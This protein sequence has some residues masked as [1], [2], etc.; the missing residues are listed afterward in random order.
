V[1]EVTG[2]LLNVHDLPWS[3]GEFPA[4]SGTIVIDDATKTIL[5]VYPNP[6]G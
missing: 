6:G 4:P 2:D 3:K 1:V 5:G